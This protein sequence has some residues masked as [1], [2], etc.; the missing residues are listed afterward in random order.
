MMSDNIPDDHLYFLREIIQAPSPENNDALYESIKTNIQ[1]LKEF[2]NSSEVSFIPTNS[3]LQNEISMINIG[4]GRLKDI[5]LPKTQKII[6]LIKTEKKPIIV[7]ELD[8]EY[9]DEHTT[10]ARY[11]CEL[12]LPFI[13]NDEVFGL[14]LVGNKEFGADYSRKEITTSNI[15]GHILGKEYKTN[16][17]LIQVEKTDNEKLN[18]ELEK[19]V[20]ELKT[21]FILSQDLNKT[22]NT[23]EILQNLLI[24]LMGQATTD[25]GIIYFK[26]DTNFEPMVKMGTHNG[27]FVDIKIPENEELI[28]GIELTN[29][30]INLNKKLIKNIIDRDLKDIIKSNEIALLIPIIAHSRLSGF[31]LLGKRLAK[32]DYSDDEFDIFETI[33][34]HASLSLENAEFFHRTQDMFRGLIRTLISLLEA[35]DP[36]MHGHTKKVT[37][38]TASF[39]DFLGITE[40]MKKDLILTC[41]LHD[42][43]KLTID[44][45]IL[46]K[47]GKYT[48]EEKKTVEE[49]VIIGTK[50]LS[51]VPLSQNILDG[52]KYHH[53]RFDGSGY[54]EGLKGEEIPYFARII[55]IT[56]AFE[57]MQSK[58][59]YKEDLSFEEAI[60]EIEDNSGTQFD[61]DLSDKFIDFITQKL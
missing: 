31:I 43:G 44:N 54:P 2:L 22:I 38:L 5:S 51:D 8:K 14:I 56:N 7:S 36:F 59:R 24:I 23:D 11:G 16:K 34:I 1:K 21:L 26:S 41:I 52:I 17:A 37:K 57:A 19:R 47:N 3:N 58:S 55:H 46:T 6:S 40:K 10:F 42:I 48:D 15:F 18:I 50:I 39:A 35:K 20:Q 12:I 27:D 28:K 53:E 49:H 61:P 25:K 13:S 60:K 9:E 4:E 30:P 45:K 33:S 29:R 32:G